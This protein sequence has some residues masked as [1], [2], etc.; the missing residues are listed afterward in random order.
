MFKQS[1]KTPVFFI[2]KKN[3]ELKNKIQKLIPYS[4]FPEHESNISSPALV[5]CLGKRLDFAITIDNGVMH[6]LSLTKVP[7]IA[8]FGP[9]DSE[10]FA[11]EYKNSIILDSKKLY[12][13]KDI[14]AITV[15][16]VLKAAKQF[17]NS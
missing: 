4:L 10:K 8:L 9:T 7:M 17:A 13:T 3:I 1:N 5:A 11:P 12:N 2:E 14:S 15:E 6:M 16:D